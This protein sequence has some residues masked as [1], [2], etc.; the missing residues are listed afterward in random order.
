MIHLESIRNGGD[1]HDSEGRWE[2]FQVFNGD[3]KVGATSV[4]S[5]ADGTALIERLDIDE[6][7]RNNGFGTQAIE[8]ISS[9]FDECYIVPDNAD[10][11]RLYARLGSE[12]YEEPWL[13]LDQGF[14]VFKV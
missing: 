8:L 1:V 10:A 7:H 13:H 5:W 14:G 11:A 3:T 9:G 12:T 4:V 6:A 2:I